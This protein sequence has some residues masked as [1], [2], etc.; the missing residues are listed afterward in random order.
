MNWSHLFVGIRGLLDFPLFRLA[1]TEVTL[2]ALLSALLVMVV[3][4]FVSA[5]LQRGVRRLVGGQGVHR[6]RGAQ[7]TGRLVHYTVMLLAFILALDVLGVNVS[8]LFAAGALFAVAIGFA[9]QNVTQ[10][11][12]S[13]VILLVERSIR[14]GDVLEVNGTVIRIE[15]MRIRATVGRTRD[16]EELIIP[17]S[18]LVAST[19]KNFTMRDSLYRVRAPVGVS[20]GSD[21]ERVRKVLEEAARGYPGREV[22][23]EPVVLLTGFGNSSVDWEASVWIDDPW[24]ARVIL[25]ELQ[26][27]MWRALGEAGITIAFPQLDV[28]LDPDVLSALEPSSRPEKPVSS[29][30]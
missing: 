30:R 14:P 24:N 7:V 4:W 8:A 13:G 18:S 5:A 11:F 29:G 12:V 15:E 9:M 6:R 21:M 20:Y 27:A 25:S 22:S 23:R 10:N 16:E 1:G 17:N 3:A 28:H 26:E 2:G 19:V